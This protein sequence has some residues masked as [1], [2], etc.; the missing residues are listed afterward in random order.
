MITRAGN[1][2]CEYC[3]GSQGEFHESTGNHVLCD[4]NAKLRARIAKLE[5]EQKSANTFISLLELSIR[6]GEVVL[7]CDECDGDGNRTEMK[8][9]DPDSARVVKCPYC[10]YGAVTYK[11]IK[12]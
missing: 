7:I 11:T 2:W 10:D 12:Q 8:G 3:K 4:D 9:N 6:A 5:A 1:F